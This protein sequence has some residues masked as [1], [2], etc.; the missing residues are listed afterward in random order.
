M[1]LTKEQ[2]DEIQRQKLLQQKEKLRLKMIDA[3]LIDAG[4]EF[5][6]VCDAQE[7]GPAAGGSISMNLSPSRIAR[8]SIN[9]EE[10]MDYHSTR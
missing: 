2:K 4:Q 3:G 10:D 8:M 7:V 1:R 6:L 5:N 9:V